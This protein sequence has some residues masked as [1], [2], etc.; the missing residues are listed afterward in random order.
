MK[1]IGIFYGTTTGATESLAKLI[2]SN[3]GVNEKDVHDVSK[4]APS[5]VGEYDVILTGASTW[6]DGDMQDDMHDFLDGVKALDLKGKM[7]AAFG[8]GDESM[9]DTFCNAVAEIYK[10]LKGTGAEMIG[11]YNSVGYHFNHSDASIN[12]TT[13]TVGLVIDDVNHSDL[14][15]N[16]VKEWTDEIKRQIS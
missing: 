11:E 14:T 15:G 7:A 9:S 2:A 10:A 6:G 12:G 8:C 1:T 16:K 13:A 5:A 4:T 3:L